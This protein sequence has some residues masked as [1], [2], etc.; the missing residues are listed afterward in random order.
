MSYRRR[1]CLTRY[2]M[3]AAKIA[4]ELE[5]TREGDALIF[6]KAEDLLEFNRRVRRL[7]N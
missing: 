7:Y 1:V 2:P 3:G 6:V 5:I 4:E